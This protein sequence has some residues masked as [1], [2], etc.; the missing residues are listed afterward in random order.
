MKNVSQKWREPKMD[1]KQQE[2]DMAEEYILSK[3]F[4]NATNPVISK[5]W[6]A[7]LILKNINYR[8]KIN[9]YLNIFE[10]FAKDLQKE[11]GYFDGNKTTQL[12]ILQ[13][14][15]LQGLVLPDIRPID[16]FRLVDNLIG[17]DKIG[18]IIQV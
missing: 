8:E 15:Y 7:I 6:E 10:I 4:S 18:E 2:L 9:E 11:N 3:L 5:K 14:P 13:F 12:M 1:I 16:F 17:L